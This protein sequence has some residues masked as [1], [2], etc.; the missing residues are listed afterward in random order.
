[1]LDVL[2]LN[3]TNTAVPLIARAIVR[4]NDDE[5]K[6]GRIKVHYPWFHGPSS[7]MPSEWATLALPYTSENSG[8]WL[9][10]EVGDQVLVFFENGNI[11]FPIVFASICGS[12]PPTAGR[13]GDLNN[14]KKNTLR[15]I[16]T[17]S[18]HLLC[19][20]DSDSDGGIVLKDRDNRSFEINSKE[21]KLTISDGQGNCVSIKGPEIEVRNSRGDCVAL[22]GGSITVDS[23]AIK[24]GEGAS[25]SLVLGEQLLTLFN[26]HMHPTAMGPSGPPTTPMTPAV[27]SQKVKTV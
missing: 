18:G 6:A 10:P 19:F 20:D 14:D 22:K 27:L 16:K 9:L 3:R 1:M 21:N 25:Q 15:F 24:L 5:K 8:L 13:S 23:T 17:R 2:Q 4:A 7:E 26:S 11:D 12:R